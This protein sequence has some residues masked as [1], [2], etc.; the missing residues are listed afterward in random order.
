MLSQFI[1]DDLVIT[2]KVERVFG[3]PREL[4]PG[5]G[6]CGFTPEDRGSL[7]WY[8]GFVGLRDINAV[9]ISEAPC[10]LEAS[11]DLYYNDTQG[12]EVH[13]ATNIFWWEITPNEFEYTVTNVWNLDGLPSSPASRTVTCEDDTCSE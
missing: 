9:L 2:E 10:I 6:E 4:P 7:D 13:F 11:Q 8:G 3:P 1:F 5:V 12:N